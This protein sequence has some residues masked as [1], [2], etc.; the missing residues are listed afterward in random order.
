MKI[1]SAIGMLM[2]VAQ[3]HVGRVTNVSLSPSLSLS[4][5]LSGNPALEKK[6]CVIA[7]PKKKKNM[8]DE[9]FECMQREFG[10]IL[11]FYFRQKLVTR[12]TMIVGLTKYK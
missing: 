12:S 10:C 9:V 6:A 11:D 5:S 7:L 2:M 4:L 8:C 3:I 1:K